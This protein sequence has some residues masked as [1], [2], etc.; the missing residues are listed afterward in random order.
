MV[1]AI[2]SWNELSCPA[3][4]P[5]TANRSTWEWFGVCQLQRATSRWLELSLLMASI[6]S[7]TLGGPVGT[8]KVQFETYRKTQ[9]TLGQGALPMGVPQQYLPKQHNT[10]STLE[11]T[12]QS[13][14]GKMVRDFTLTN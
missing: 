12:I 8:Y 10:D 11:I 2:V 6:R 9:S 1:A 14:S 7:T 3:L 4:S 5:I 13:G